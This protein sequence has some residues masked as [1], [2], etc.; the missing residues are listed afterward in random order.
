ML[1]KVGRRVWHGGV[2]VER[3]GQTE[4]AGMSSREMLASS[5]RAAGTWAQALN[6]SGWADCAL[7]LGRPSPAEPRKQFLRRSAA[8]A[9][10]QIVYVAPLLSFILCWNANPCKLFWASLGDSGWGLMAGIV[11]VVR[12]GSATLVGPVASPQSALAHPSGALVRLRRPALVNF[13]AR[14]RLAHCK[15]LAKN[16]TGRAGKPEPRPKAMAQDVVAKTLPGRAPPGL[17]PLLRD[18]CCKADKLQLSTITMLVVCRLAWLRTRK[19][20]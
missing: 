5:P 9:P 4:V 14:P 13:P 3:K 19:T 12:L 8:S 15:W 11:Y 16:T 10:I 20:T 18:C 1:E 7:Q 17:L 2:S 6:A